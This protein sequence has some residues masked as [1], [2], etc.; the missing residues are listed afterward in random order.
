[1]AKK[2]RVKALNRTV[3]EQHL[4]AS[5]RRSAVKPNVDMPETSQEYAHKVLME[6]LEEDR[7]EII[8]FGEPRY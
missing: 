3:K 2:T 1:M 4:G 6:H 7:N 5:S 8:R